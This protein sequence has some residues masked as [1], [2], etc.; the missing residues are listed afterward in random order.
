MRRLELQ[1]GDITPYVRDDGTP[2]RIGDATPLGALTEVYCESEP[3]DDDP[4]GYY[5]GVVAGGAL[6]TVQYGGPNQDYR[7]T[8]VRDALIAPGPAGTI[9]EE[10]REGMRE[11]AKDSRFTNPTLRSRL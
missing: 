10:P 3:S 5:W 2:V 4:G 6:H 9:I 1:A 7:R 11:M 8:F